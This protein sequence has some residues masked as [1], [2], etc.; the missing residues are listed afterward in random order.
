VL[1]LTAISALLGLI[2]ALTALKRS[3][4]DGLSTRV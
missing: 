4:S 1:G 2:P 3:V